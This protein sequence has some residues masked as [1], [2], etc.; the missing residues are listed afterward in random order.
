M[1]ASISSCPGDEILIL[2]NKQTYRQ[3]SKQT[4]R[5]INNNKEEAHKSSSQGK[6]FGSFLNKGQGADGDDNE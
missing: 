5:V 6:C 3:A 1:Q 4:N 2:A